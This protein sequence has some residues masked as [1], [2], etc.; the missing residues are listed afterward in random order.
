MT[1]MIKAFE[2]CYHI[3]RSCTVKVIEAIIYFDKDKMLLPWFDK[4]FK[5]KK[6]LILHSSTE[7]FMSY[8]SKAA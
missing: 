4:L 5:H 8:L 2:E 6:Q 1:F 7:D 3:P